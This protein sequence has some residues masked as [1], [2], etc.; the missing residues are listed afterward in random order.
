MIKAARFFPLLSEPFL[1][2]PLYVEP[3]LLLLLLL[4]LLL[5]VALSQEDLFGLKRGPSFESHVKFVFQSYCTMSDILLAQFHSVCGFN[6]AVYHHFKGN[7][8]SYTLSG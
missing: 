7:R 5:I 1:V 3:I 6:N 8:V 2:S 4:L